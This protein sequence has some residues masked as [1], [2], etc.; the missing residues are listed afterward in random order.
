M[1]EVNYD[2]ATKEE[3]LEHLLRIFQRTVLA[4]PE[5]DCQ[6]KIKEAHDQLKHSWELL[7]EIKNL[8]EST[9]RY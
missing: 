1:I 7:K 8:K 4:F 6:I 5:N 2:S 3:L 9:G